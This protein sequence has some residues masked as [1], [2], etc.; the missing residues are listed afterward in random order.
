MKKVPILALALMMTFIFINNSYAQN[1]KIV[2]IKGEVLLRQRDVLPWRKA[3]MGEALYKDYELQTKK[4]SECTISFDDN[5][6][7]VL[8]LKENTQ[9]KIEDV[10]HTSIKLSKGRVFSLLENMGVGEK[11]NIH[12]KKE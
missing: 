12:Q 4:G 9:I 1:L 11:L 6:D 8:T 10:I 2:D 7:K 3:V 5:L